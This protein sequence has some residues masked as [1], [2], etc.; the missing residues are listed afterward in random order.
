MNFLHSKDTFKGS[1]I[2]DKQH[3]SFLQASA[4]EEKPEH[5]DIIPKNIVKLEKL[6]DLQEKFRG[7]TNTK[8]RSSTL[9][10]EVVNLG[11]EQDPKNINLGKNCTSTK[12]ATFMKYSESIRMSSHGH[13]KI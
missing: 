11:T 4:L 1:I 7:S 3:E 2:D 8:T 9:L 5:S 6:L 10:Y 13:M 12:R